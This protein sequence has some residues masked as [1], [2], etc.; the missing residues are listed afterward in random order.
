MKKVVQL[1]ILSFCFLTGNAQ[2]TINVFNRVT[3]YDGYAARVDSPAPPA[4]ILRLRNYIY[5]RKLTD[6]EIASIGT[7]LHLNVRIFALCDNYDRIG[8]VNMAFVP[9]DSSSYNLNNVTRLEIARFITP[10]MDKNKSPNSVP[11]DFDIDN[12]ALLLKDSSL[13]DRFNIWME[14]QVFGVPYAANNEIAGCAGRKDVFQGSMT[15]TTDSAAPVQSNNMLKVFANQKNFNNYQASATDTLGKTTRQYNFRVDTA[16][17]DASFFLITSNHGANSGGEEYNRRRHYVYVDDSLMLSYVPGRTTCEPFRVYNTQGNGI[18]GGSPRSDDQWQSFSNWCP[19]DVIDIRRINLGAVDTGSHYFRINVPEAVF[20]G[21]QGNFPLSVYFQG[22]TSGTI[23]PPAP[24]V[25][26]SSGNLRI[27][28]NPARESVTIESLNMS[29]IRIYDM[30]GRLL[31]K[32]DQPAEKQQVSVYQWPRGMYI[33]QAQNWKG[34]KV[35]KLLVE[36]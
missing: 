15:L 6:Q 34:R 31:Y 21:S 3:F 2:T 23:D 24:I 26:D 29:S 27:Y 36:R 7:K 16:L 13:T 18:Y 33:V 4:G 30:T 28:P 22:K 12:I 5:S 25:K 14:L 8:N 17:T 20:V 11:Y 19:G 9:K 32:N 35:G 1:L 10:F